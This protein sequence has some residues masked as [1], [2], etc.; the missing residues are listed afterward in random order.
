MNAILWIVLGIL[1]LVILFLLWQW[2]TEGRFPW[3][4]V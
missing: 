1:L 2:L 3:Q 4:P